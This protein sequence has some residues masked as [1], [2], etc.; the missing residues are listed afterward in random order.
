MDIAHILALLCVVALPACSA[1]SAESSSESEES[2]APDCSIP[3]VGEGRC[4]PN[5][6]CDCDRHGD[7]VYAMDGSP[8]DP[9]DIADCCQAGGDADCRASSGCALY[10]ECSYYHGDCAPLEDAD[11]AGSGICT[12]MGLCWHCSPA[13]CGDAPGC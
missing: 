5:G 1:A 12:Y 13:G 6:A 2:Y 8:V 11:C 10:G 7:C 3:C 4:E 9:F